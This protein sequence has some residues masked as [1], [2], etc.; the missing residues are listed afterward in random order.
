[1]SRA[2]DDEKLALTGRAQ[3]TKDEAL[4]L[5]RE[6]FEASERRLEAAKQVVT[7][8]ALTDE[9]RTAKMKEIFGL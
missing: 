8:E 5:Q 3:Q 7:N 6:K 9:Q 1:M 2:G 4:R